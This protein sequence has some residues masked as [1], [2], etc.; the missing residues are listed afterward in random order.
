MTLIAKAA[1]QRDVCER[2]L[3]TIEQDFRA[4]D[5]LPDEPLV[6]RLTNGA[7]EG[8]AELRNG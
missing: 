5:A 8:P 1:C 3:V 6:W 4:L 2:R 7:P